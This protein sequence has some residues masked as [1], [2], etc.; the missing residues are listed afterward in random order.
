MLDSPP[1]VLLLYYVL[2]AAAVVSAAAMAYWVGTTHREGHGSTWL[3]AMVVSGGVTNLLY[4]VITVSEDRSVQWLSIFPRVLALVWCIGAYVLYCSVYT[5]RDFHREPPVRAAL[6]LVLGGFTVLAVTGPFHDLLFASYEERSVP[7]GYVVADP[8]V[9]FVVLTAGLLLFAVY[10]TYVMG[11]YLLSTTRRSSL[12]IVLLMVGTLSIAAM[13]LAGNVGLFP[14][15]GLSHGGYGVFPFLLGLFVAMFRFDLLD[16][17]PVARAQ[18]VDQLRDPVIVVDADQRV[19]DYNDASA[20]VWPAL[21]GDLSKPF[22]SICPSLAAEI[23]L[24]PAETPVTTELTLASDSEARHYSVTVSAVTRGNGG[25]TELY[26]L[27]LRDVTDLEHSRR[28]L[29]T[30]NERLDQVASTI[31]HDLRNPINVADGHAEMLEERFE[32]S[33]LDGDGADRAE[34]SLATIRRS[35]RR[36]TEIVDD[37]LTIAREGT[38]VEET[39]PVSLEAVATEAWVTVGTGS[40]SLEVVADGTV[41]ADRSRLVTVLENLFRNAVEHGSTNPASQARQ[42]AVEHGSTS[43]ADVTVTVEP[44]PDGFAVAD[45]GPGI[46]EHVRKRVFDDGYTTEPENTGLGL[47]IV[48]TMAESHGWTVA[49]DETYIEGARFVFRTTGDPAVEADVDTPLPGSW[50]E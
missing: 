24:P 27:L 11:V 37:V 8:S 49:L 23:D 33:E 15:T 43:T 38:T 36:M 1:G 47:S 13:E 25:P 21:S 18:V 44:T 3:L 22:A 17:R 31:S 5:G 20:R 4:L 50:T 12:Q 34:E 26:A 6:A 10:S 41:H 16:V 48:R 40:A 29:A 32:E 39:E 28:H 35:H 14:A 19:V 30:Q 9:L 2:P 46:D 45:D 7:F 42:D